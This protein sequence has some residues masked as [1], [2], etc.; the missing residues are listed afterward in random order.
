M[1]LLSA[2]DEV[3]LNPPQ[4]SSSASLQL[5][6]SFLLLAGVWKTWAQNWKSWWWHLTHGTCTGLYPVI[7]TIVFG[8]LPAQ[9]PFCHLRQMCQFL[10]PCWRLEGFSASER[11]G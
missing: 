2:P 3:L 6:Y 9:E 7:G 4:G 10:E 5:T 11:S 1:C 8:S